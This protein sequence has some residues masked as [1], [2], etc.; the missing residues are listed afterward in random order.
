MT[1]INFQQI[2]EELMSCMMQT[3]NYVNSLNFMH[4]KQL[5]LLRFY[6]SQING[7]A[8]CLDM[9]FKEAVAAD[10]TELRLYSVS[11]W[12]E[13]SFYTDS[14][15]AMLQWAKSVTSLNENPIEQQASFSNLNEYFNIEEIANLTLVIIQINSWNRLAKSFGLEAGSVAIKLAS[16]NNT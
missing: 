11:V 10:E 7:C 15:R 2:P 5:E 4:K 16:I 1:R 13:T 9:H 8:Y 12:E 6:I 3:E 14:E